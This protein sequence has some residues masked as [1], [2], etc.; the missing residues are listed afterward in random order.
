MALAVALTLFPIALIVFLMVNRRFAADTSGIVG[1][2]ATLLIAVTAFNT[3]VEMGLRS[4]LAG[5]IASFPVSLMVVTSAV[6][7]K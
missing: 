3:P 5:V 4:S 2:L 7:Y 6:A 1:W